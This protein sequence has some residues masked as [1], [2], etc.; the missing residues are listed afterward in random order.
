MKPKKIQA[1]AVFELLLVLLVTAIAFVWGSL[2]A[3]MER[4]YDAVGGEYLLLLFPA[5]YYTGKKM[6]LDGIAELRKQN[7]RMKKKMEEKA[8]RELLLAGADEGQAQLKITGTFEGLFAWAKI[9]DQ[10]CRGLDI[11][12]AAL[13]GMMPHLVN[14]YRRA[15]LNSREARMD[16]KAGAGR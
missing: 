6:I 16:G 7:E 15:A 1:S 13:A 12:P 11:S 9:T 4:G 5:V 3:R 14:D 8:T 2:V 10:L